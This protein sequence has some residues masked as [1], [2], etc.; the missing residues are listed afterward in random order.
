MGVLELTVSDS[1]AVGSLFADEFRAELLRG[2]VPGGG[3]FSLGTPMQQ[4]GTSPTVFQ[5]QE[6][7]MAAPAG[8]I[9][10]VQGPRSFAAPKA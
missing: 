10:H 1:V 4:F 9:N 3:D 8:Q 6:S 2:P 5:G 7:Y